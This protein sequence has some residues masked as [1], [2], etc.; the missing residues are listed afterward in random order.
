MAMHRQA[1]P[2]APAPPHAA[3][4]PVHAVSRAGA[5]VRLMAG[6]AGFG[7]GSVDLA[8]SSSII[9]GGSFGA[10]LP[11]LAGGIAGL[12]GAGMLAATVGFLARGSLADSSWTRPALATAS[13]LHV[14][15]VVFGTPG[16]PGLALTQLSALLLTLLIMASLAWLRRDAALHANAPHAMMPT[17]SVR[18]ARLL[19]TAFAG[20]VLV[21]GIAT[22]G[23]AASAAGQYAVPH[24]SHGTVPAGGHHPR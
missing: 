13:G 7:A 23:L 6:F 16:A 8:I 17:R 1:A 24:G 11:L 22:P 9:A 3:G 18:P 14:A 15:A 5:S 4:S 19:V 12:W 21:A 2:A 20:A 10:A